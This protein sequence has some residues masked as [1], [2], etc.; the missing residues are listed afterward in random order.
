[1]TF[2][3]RLWA[4]IWLF[5]YIGPTCFRHYLWMLGEDDT[6]LIYDPV[7]MKEMVQS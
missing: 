2:M 3:R 4:G 7:Q 1:M 5:F 6:G